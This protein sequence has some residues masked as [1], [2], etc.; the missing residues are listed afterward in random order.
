MKVLTADAPQATFEECSVE[1]ARFG[2]VIR[3]Y[4]AW[5]LFPACSSGWMDANFCLR[6]QPSSTEGPR[7]F[8]DNY[9]PRDPIQTPP[10]PR[11]PLPAR[12]ARSCHRT[13]DA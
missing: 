11:R 6:Q 12:T 3:G 1:Q 8:L 13:T 2:P 10:R 4:V 9:L 5:E 7:G